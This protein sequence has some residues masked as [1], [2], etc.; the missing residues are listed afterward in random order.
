MDA[1]TSLYEKYNRIFR[2]KWPCDF[3]KKCL[4]FDISTYHRCIY[5]VQATNIICSA[6][7]F[8]IYL[9]QLHNLQMNASLRIRFRWLLD[10]SLACY[11]CMP[12]CMTGRRV[13]NCVTCISVLLRFRYF[14][15]ARSWML[16]GVFIDIYG[17]YSLM[18]IILAHICVRE[19]F[20]NIKS[21][22][23][24]SR[25]LVRKDRSWRHWKNDPLLIFVS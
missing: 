5:I 11:A 19:L 16:G 23:R 8:F 21:Q 6:S 25:L 24:N 14:L 12:I 9:I 17:C 18:K 2:L 20:T 1:F 3:K 4:S 13:G 15:Y 7:P 22:N 10:S